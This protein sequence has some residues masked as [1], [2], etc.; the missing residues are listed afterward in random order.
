MIRRPAIQANNFEL[1]S[2]TFK[3][4][5]GIQ[6]HGLAH[7]DP[8]AH[9]LNFL[10]VCDTV[11]F[12]GVRDDAIRL[13]LFSFSLNDKAK[14]WLISEPPDSIT[15]WDD[16]SN[17]FLARF[18][19]PKK[20]ANLRIDISSFYLYEGEWFYETWERFKDLLR[21]CP[22]HS[23]TKWT[24]VHHFYNWLS[25]PTRTL[26]DAYVGGAIMGKNEVEA[27]QIF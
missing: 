24:Q 23:F 15:S 13:R 14:H 11:K 27:Y 9:I 18:F 3:L 4:L 5:Q 25:H 20:V 22:H 7:E 2:I 10:E 26:I 6:F 8:N 17:K 12:K 1:K 16:L 21:K 19:P